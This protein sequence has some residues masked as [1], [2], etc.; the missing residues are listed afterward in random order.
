MPTAASSRRSRKAV[1]LLAVLLVVAILSLAAYQYCDFITAEYRA[2]DSS[3]RSA[4][5]RDLADS[6]I[7]YAAALLSNPDSMT[8]LLNNNPFD[9]TQAFQAQPVGA[10][11]QHAQGLFSVVAPLWPDDAVSGTQSYRYGVID[12]SGKINLNALLQL[13]SS[14]QKAHDLLMLLP[15]MT[16][17][18]A[19]AILDWLD[20]DDDPRVNGAENT[21]YQGLTPP[22]Y[23]KNGPLDSL[24]EL[25]LVKGVTPQLLYGDDVNRT[26]FHDDGSAAD[27]GWSAYLTV[28]THETNV[29]SQGNPRTY[30]NDSDINSLTEKLTTALGDEM[31]R[32]IVAYRMYGPAQ[33]GGNA[34]GAQG[35][36]SG[37]PAGNGAGAKVLTPATNVSARPTGAGAAVAATPAPAT[38]AYTPLSSADRQTFNNQLNTDR[39]SSGQR[40]MTDI[41]SIYDLINAT[42]AVPVTGNGTGA[43]SGAAPAAGAARPG[44]DGGTQQRTINL[45]SPLNDAGQLKQLLPILLDQTTTTQQTDLPGRVNINTAPQ[46]VLLTLPGLTNTDVQTI[47]SQ[48]PDPSSLNAPDASF[49]TPAWLLTQANLKAS[50]LKSLEKYITARTQV[51][52]VQSVGYFEG[53]GPSVRLEAIIDTNQGRPRILFWRDLT[54]LGRGFDVTGGQ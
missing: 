45:P 44:Q 39:Q 27:R 1:V 7:H 18:I 26:G 42:V 25:L 48:R 24:E 40:K 4:Q 9:N 8:N 51:Y 54:E 36:N 15:N 43:G 28:Y 31:A 12:E 22:Y 10:G 35:T 41:S 37:A 34:S 38:A 14:G 6:G 50:T 29:D 19:N 30:L 49:S 52:R 13:D 46:A 47:M 32:F 20:P 5:A 3:R 33:T 11:D 23:C 53:G 16:E 21:Y 2:A 17:D